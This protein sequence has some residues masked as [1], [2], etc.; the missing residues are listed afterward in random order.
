MFDFKTNAAAQRSFGF[1]KIPS[2]PVFIYGG[3]ALAGGPTILFYG[4]IG[5]LGMNGFWTSPQIF[6]AILGR[7][8]FRNRFGEEKWTAY[9]PV[10]LAGYGCGFGLVGMMC[11][12]IALIAKSVSTTLF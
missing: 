10:L 4:M 6:G 3:L 8:Y 9:A 12:G 7:Y 2:V 5:G 11:V 1:N